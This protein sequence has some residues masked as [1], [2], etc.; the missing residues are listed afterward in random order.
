MKILIAEDDL[1]LRPLWMAFFRRC[2][3]EPEVTWVVSG[4]EALRVLR[5]TPNGQAYDLV[6][7]DLFLAGSLTGLDIINSDLVKRSK[8][9]TV[10]VTFA[11]PQDIRQAHLD[12]QDKTVL[13]KKPINLVKCESMLKHLVAPGSFYA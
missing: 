2:C 5:E 10:L 4:E 11:D 7:S 8:A 13:I 1:S 6:I 9:L 3:L 12:F